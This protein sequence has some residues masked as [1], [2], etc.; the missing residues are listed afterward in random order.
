VANSCSSAF[1]G[2]SGLNQILEG[3][4]GR[5]PP[6]Q[7]DKPMA[8]KRK[9]TTG[10]KKLLVAKAKPG[11]PPVAK[12]AAKSAPVAK[13]AAMPAQEPVAAE[14]KVLSDS[15]NCVHSRAYKKAAK[16]AKLDGLNKAQISL[17]ACKAARAAA[18]QWDLD[19]T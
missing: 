13:T 7:F 1:S 6:M 19:H 10:S 16:Q 8:I 3:L 17:A 11:Q 12:A 18:E 2:C 4:E 5:G 9:A 15:R 14:A